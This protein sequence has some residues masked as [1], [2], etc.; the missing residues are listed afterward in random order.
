[1]PTPQLELLKARDLVVDTEYFFDEQESLS[2][3]V[4]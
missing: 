1:M 2:K 3:G 4:L